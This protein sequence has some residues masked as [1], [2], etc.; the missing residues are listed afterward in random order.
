MLTVEAGLSSDRVKDVSFPEPLS[1]TNPKIGVQFRPWSRTTLRAA[2]LRTLRRAPIGDQTIE[3]TQVAGVNQ[4]YEDF[5]GTDA[6]T[7]AVGLDQRLS[8]R[9]FAGFEFAK[10]R[11]TV[12][13]PFTDPTD[14]FHWNQTEDRAYLYWVPHELVSTSIEYSYEHITEDPLFS[15][16]FLDA[17]THKV[18]ISVRLFVPQP[19]VSLRLTVTGVRQSGTFRLGGG[20]ADGSSQFWLTDVGVYYRLPRRY[21]LISLEVRNLFDRH[22]MYYTRAGAFCI[23]EVHADVQLREIDH[24]QAFPFDGCLRDSCS[25]S[26][27]KFLY[28]SKHCFGTGD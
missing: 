21:G 20:F 10:R 17:K 9:L 13:Q 22:F 7:S 23:R 11:L 27:R 4:F 14:F 16:A 24:D 26:L 28:D 3:P 25:C 15:E 12:P 2:Y 6:K 8:P 5:L 1:Q 19:A 18:P